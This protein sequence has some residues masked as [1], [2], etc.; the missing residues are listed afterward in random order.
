MRTSCLLGASARG[1]AEPTSPSPPVL[2]NGA[3]SEETNRIF[4]RAE[5]RTSLGGGLRS[6]VMDFHIFDDDFQRATHDG[7]VLVAHHR[8][9][10]PLVT[11]VLGRAHRRQLGVDHQLA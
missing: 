4:M 3:T 5:W 7:F 6:C 2:A 8:V 11:V 1:S 10:V 9:A